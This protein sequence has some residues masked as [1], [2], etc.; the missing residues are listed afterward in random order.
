MRVE[1]SAIATFGLILFGLLV[2]F[3]WLTQA[4]SHYQPLRVG[5]SPTEFV[6]R[7]VLGHVT[8]P[9]LGWNWWAFFLGP[10]WFIAEGIWF[11][12]IILLL[13]ATLSG[14]VLLPFVMVYSAMKSRET[15]EDRR[16]ARHT[17]Y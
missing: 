2:F 12:G 10:V 8:P 15:L 5:A 11:H 9:K 6:A 13:L 14:G 1:A 7:D 4:L 16:I 3:I 17:F